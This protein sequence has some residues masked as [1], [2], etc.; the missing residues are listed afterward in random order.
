[1]NTVEAEKLTLDLME[2]HGLIKKGWV[3]KYDK[4]VQRFGCCHWSK[5][6]ITL[7]E[8]LVGMNDEPEV[9]NTILHEIA[10]ALADQKEGHGAQWKTIAELIGATPERCY[11]STVVAT[12]KAKYIRKCVKGCGRERKLYRKPKRSKTYCGYC[13]R[14]GNGWQLLTVRRIQE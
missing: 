11:D 12:P 13:W 9:R 4:A 14:N 1:M 10:H 8:A 6:M 5:Q 2:K 3:F 7:S